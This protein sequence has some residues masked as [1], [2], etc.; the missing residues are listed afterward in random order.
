MAELPETD[1]REVGCRY[2]EVI[3]KGQWEG[4][5]LGGCTT[6]WG[7]EIGVLSTAGEVSV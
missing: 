2:D 3:S 6:G 5:F 1:C 4:F 7:E